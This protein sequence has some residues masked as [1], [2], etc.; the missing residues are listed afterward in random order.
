M[1]V[2]KT[3][4]ITKTKSQLTDEIY[5]EMKTPV[6]KQFTKDF[7]HKTGSDYIM[8]KAFLIDSSCLASNTYEGA[9]FTVRTPDGDIIKVN[10][11][12]KASRM[13]GK[14]AK[15][16]NL[17]GYEEFRLK[18]S[19]CLNQKKLKGTLCLSIHP[20]DYITMSDNASNWNSCM[21]WEDDGC[22]KQG[23][24][25]MMNSPCVVVAYL[26][27]SQDMSLGDGTF[28]N[29]KKW[30]Q[31][32][33]IHKDCIAGVKGYPYRSDGLVEQA[34]DWI[35]NMV[36]KDKFTVPQKIQPFYAQTI[37]GIGDV[38]FSPET[39]MMY[40]DFA[41]DHWV[42]FNKE[43]VHDGDRVEFYYS[44]LSECMHCGAAGNEVDFLGEGCLVCERCDTKRACEYCGEIWNDDELT[45]IDG[46]WLCP[47][48]V[49]DDTEEDALTGIYHLRSNMKCIHLAQEDIH[50]VWANVW[51][52]VDKDCIEQEAYGHFF[53]KLH[54]G[55]WGRL[56]VCAADCTKEGLR[57]FGFDSMKELE[58]YRV[59]QEPWDD[60]LE[61]W[62]P[63]ETVKKNRLHPTNE[64]LMNPF[65]GIETTKASTFRDG[66]ITID[67]LSGAGSFVPSVG[68]VGTNVKLSEDEI[69]AAMDEIFDSLNLSFNV[70]ARPPN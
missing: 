4:S 1:I 33:I 25:E 14:I 42:A 19:M 34:M 53:K 10:S 64:L 29:N 49:A 3:V 18:H 26:K 41:E 36:G 6:I 12:C 67:S 46:M 32:F 5:A 40:N 59:R 17:E 44:G 8:E 16:F 38:V 47:D 21:S 65:D 20:L 66:Y 15:A 31:L 24:V 2:E 22:Y 23:T 9:A 61:D 57:V 35:L 51:I 13:I 45:E 60:V 62:D 27:G 63:D 39:Y 11:S 37:D 30:R 54:R 50:K 48:C 28:W 56:F 43:T 58:D 52:Y 55:T 70:A 69:R 7:I 68:E